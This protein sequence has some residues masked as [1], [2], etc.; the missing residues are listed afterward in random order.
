MA[1]PKNVC[2]KV[3]ILGDSSVGKTSLMNQYVTKKF[4]NDYQATMGADFLMKEIVINDRVVTMQ[5]FSFSFLFFYRPSKLLYM[6]VVYVCKIIIYRFGI[7]LDKND[8]SHFV[9][10]IFGAPIVVF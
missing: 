9:C 10:H 6:R 3:V 8:S 5:V 2:L 1:T 7:Q 4:S